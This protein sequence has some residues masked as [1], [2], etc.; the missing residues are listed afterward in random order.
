MPGGTAAIDSGRP[1][2]LPGVKTATSR[3]R[4]SAALFPSIAGSGNGPAQASG[5]AYRQRSPLRS[6]RIAGT[7]RS[8]SCSTIDS[9]TVVLPLPEAPRNAACM[10]SSSGSDR[11]RRRVQPRGHADHERPRSGVGPLDALGR[12][13][14]G[15][16]PAERSSAS[17]R[18]RR[19]QPGASPSGRRAPGPSATTSVG[20]AV[21]RRASQAAKTGS[22]RYCSRNPRIACIARQSESSTTTRRPPRVMSFAEL[23]RHGGVR[24]G[25]EF[26]RSHDDGRDRGRPVAR[27]LLH[28]RNLLAEAAAPGIPVADGDQQPLDRLVRGVTLDGDHRAG[29]LGREMVAGRHLVGARRDR[30][31]QQGRQFDVIRGGRGGGRAGVVPEL[32]QASRVVDDVDVLL[33]R[34]A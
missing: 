29:G 28:L 20:S 30:P 5:M 3:R 13:R 12:P 17:G 7:P 32:L 15:F 4:L 2:G 27:P 22:S 18:R 8:R 31:G 26:R 34:V 1:S 16:R 9:A 24:A 19:R 23:S 21:S 14:L 11:H 25:R 6:T 33:G 10:V